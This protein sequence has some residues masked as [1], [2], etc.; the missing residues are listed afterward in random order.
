[1]LTPSCNRC[2]WQVPAIRR[3][4]PSRT[5]PS[6]AQHLLSWL[7]QG[8][9]PTTWHGLST[10][11]THGRSVQLP[12]L[13]AFGQLALSR[14]VVA[15][16]SEMTNQVMIELLFTPGLLCP[17]SPAWASA[18]A[19]DSALPAPPA[20][21]PPACQVPSRF[22]SQRWVLVLE[23]CCQA[24]QTEGRGQNSGLA[25]RQCQFSPERLWGRA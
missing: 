20:C 16:P 12:R 11:K 23:G 25:L 14:D 6:P 10:W 4:F 24:A 5:I 21:G 22:L 13:S 19:A 17:G 8:P 3:P 18:S 7:S 9:P 15:I 1:M 2:V